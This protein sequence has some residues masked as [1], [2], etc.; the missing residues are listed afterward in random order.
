MT[1]PHFAV[2][3]LLDLNLEMNDLLNTHFMRN[4][5]LNPH[6]DGLRYSRP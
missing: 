3:D 2:N 5:M 6:Q 1:Y 4:E